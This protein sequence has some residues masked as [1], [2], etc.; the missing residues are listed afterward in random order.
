M[1]NA[2]REEALRLAGEA[3]NDEALVE[4]LAAFAHDKQWSGW[5][6]YLFSK[7]SSPYTTDDFRRPM[8]GDVAIPAWAVERWTRQMQTPYAEL[9]EE[10]RESDR[11][12][13]RKILEAVQPALA[14]ALREMVGQVERLERYRDE[15]KVRIDSQATV[16]RDKKIR[17]RELS[18][19]LE[20]AEGVLREAKL[21]IE[22]TDPTL[23]TSHAGREL[24]TKI[25]AVLP[26]IEKEGSAKKPKVVCLC[27][28]TRFK[29]EYAAENRRLTLE[30][31][32]VLSVGLFAGSGDAVTE[33]QK[34]ALDELHFRKIDLA[35]E[36][37]VIAP[38]DYIG[39]STRR[40]IDYAEAAGKPVSFVPDTGKEQ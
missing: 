10:E 37:L 8:P 20:R 21:Y 28:S 6:R 36:I 16:I 18:A 40:E 38:G 3:I 14:T 22:D 1:S 24:F 35:D 12:E 34:A 19:R 17:Q 13:A 15:L 25:D 7:C 4:K 33:E 27:G 39:S 9:P 26:D 30:G 29:D 31:K 2:K 5:M 23:E 11:A 32:I